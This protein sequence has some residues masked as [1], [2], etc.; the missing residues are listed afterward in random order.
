MLFVG[1]DWAEEHH[2][3][4]VQDEAGKVLKRVRLPEGI[5]GISRFHELVAR[6][7][8]EDAEPSD[9]L[10][11]IE[12]DRGPWVRAL[13]AAG[14]RVFGV[15]PKQAARHREILSSSG[16]KSD[17]GDAHALADMVRTRHHQLLE[18]AGD[19]EVAEAVK[20]VTRA[21]Q[22][23][24][25]ER[26]RHMLRL[27]VA[28]RDYFP[29]A[30]D[31][32]KPLGLTS[33]PVLKLLAKAPTSAAAA[34]LTISQI[35]AALKGRRDIA[36]KAAA[37]QQS[38]RGEHL[39]Q[40]GLVTAAYASTVRA[41]V[42]V[43]TTLNA[44]I[45]TLE[46]EVEAHF[47]RHPDAE[48][49]LSQPGIGVVLGARVLAE[50]GDAPGRYTSAKAR[51]NYAGTSPITRQSGKMRTV[52]ARF[53]HNDRLVDALHLQASCAI[54]H[55]SEVRAYYDQLRARD[56]GH[57]AALRQVGNRLVGILHGCLKTRTH[58]DQTTAWSHRSQALIA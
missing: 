3:V 39:G 54:L 10:V 49:I 56:V 57:N 29:A 6:F 1:D 19:S 28:L 26:T 7:V 37:I 11:C 33:E 5:A 44:E 45:S 48:I 51:K 20:V 35:S 25:W 17:R 21:H 43:I 24:L 30:L 18:V 14:Y 50:F 58:Y 13:R 16:A 23:L 22:T 38:L 52:H 31:A 12:T 8:A 40:S 34:K 15:D 42:A 36:G 4:E 46:S 47:G 2:D 9:V 27:R 55:D 41:L 53:V 32:Y